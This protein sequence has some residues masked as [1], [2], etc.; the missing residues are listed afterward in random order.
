[1]FALYLIGLKLVDI[2]IRI[3]MTL[4][5]VLITNIGYLLGSIIGGLTVIKILENDH[6]FYYFTLIKGSIYTISLII[7]FTI[8][9][10][11]GINESIFGKGSSSEGVL[12]ES[13]ERN[14]NK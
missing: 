2:E 1:V 13:S 11:N 9:G 4:Y 12:T 7:S 5:Y 6:D 8:L 3:T 14:Q 10:E